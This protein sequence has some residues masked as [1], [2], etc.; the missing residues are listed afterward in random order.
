MEQRLINIIGH[1]NPD[2]D[3]ICSAIAYAY[4]KNIG[5]PGHYVA[6]RAGNINNETNFVLDYFGV[7]APDY[8]EDVNVQMRD[9]DFRE[10]KGVPDT[11]SIRNAWQLMKEQDVVTLPIIQNGNKLEGL[12]TINDIAKSY[13]DV[14]DNNI[15]ALARTPISNLMEVLEGNLVCGNPHA[16]IVNGKVLIGAANIDIMD[17]CIEEDDLVLVADREETQKAAIEQGAFCIIVC[18]NAKISPEII[19][20]AEEHQCNIIT[21]YYDTYSAARMINQCIPIRY[22]MRRSNLVTFQLDD[23]LDSVKEIMSK[24]R[25]R[26]F[27]VTDAVGNY[28]GMVSRRNLLAMRRKQVILVDHNERSQAVTGIEN[29]EILEII[30]HHRI[31]SMETIDPVYFRNQPVGCTATIVYQMYLEQGVTPPK[32]MAGLLCSAILSDTLMFRSPTCTPMDES[33]A[34]Q[35]SSLA[36]I[37]IETYAMEMFAAGSDLVGKSPEEIFYQ[38]FKT[39]QVGDITFGA[40]QISSLNQQ[41]L[42]ELQVKIH[43]YL[44]ASYTATKCDMIFFVMTNILDEG[45]TMLFYGEQAD[46]LVKEAF[47]TE[48]TDNTCYLPGVVSRKKQIVPLLVS[49]LQQWDN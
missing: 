20:L 4:L 13:M 31:G 30:D 5:H 46:V 34:R 28:Y 25:H 43:A 36:G 1:K 22:F 38:D 41:E 40:G 37:D 3:S 8:L 29:A 10:T 17:A 26:D 18:L 44:E 19:R 7:S 21:T 39:F 2:T 27:P 16:R 12:I 14:F 42:E 47:Q 9:I 6:R 24:L 33:A 23:T 48:L 45:S 35:L 32:Q 49:T 15:L 11:I